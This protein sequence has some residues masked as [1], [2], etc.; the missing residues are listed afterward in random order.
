MNFNPDILNKLSNLFPLAESPHSAGLSHGDCVVVETHARS[1]VSGAKSNDVQPFIFSLIPPTGFPTNFPTYDPEAI[2]QHDIKAGGITLYNDS[3]Y[4]SRI[5]QL[6][7]IRDS[8]TEIQKSVNTMNGVPPLVMLIPPNSFST[9]WT[10][11]IADGQYTRNGHII[12]P[13][14]EQLIDIS[15]DG[16]IGAYYDAA[17]GVNRG[18]RVSSRS[19]QNFMALLQIYQNNG[20]I[21]ENDPYGSHR[22]NLVGTVMLYHDGVAY[23]GNFDEFSVDEDAESPFTLSYSFKFT[24]SGRQD[25]YGKIN[26]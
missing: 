5:A 24:A 18:L 20:A 2:S 8:Y 22:I 3:G 21:I 6:D 15:C 7:Q 13:W 16:K 25:V 10:K 11:L 26:K 14:G 12:D 19:Y 1:S 4:D 17:I 23:I 9:N